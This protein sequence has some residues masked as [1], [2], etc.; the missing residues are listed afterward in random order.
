MNQLTYR[1]SF[2]RPPPIGSP[3]KCE[4]YGTETISSESKSSSS[5]DAK[6]I[7]AKA[8]GLKEVVL[9]AP[10]FFEIDAKGMDGLVDIKITGT[11]I[12]A[13]FPILSLL[14]YKINPFVY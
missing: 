6:Q 7:I 4:I 5:S 9:G 13:I 3:F 14:L 2:W 11:K 8:E 10:A 1:L 12:T